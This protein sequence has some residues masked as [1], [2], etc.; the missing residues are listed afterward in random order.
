MTIYNIAL[1]L[2]IVGALIMGSAQVL[3]TIGVN[4]IRQAKTTMDLGAVFGFVR[5]LSSLYQVSGALIL[6]SGIYLTIAFWGAEAWIIISLVMVLLLAVSGP[7]VSGVRFREIGQRSAAESGTLSPSLRS[8]TQ[9]PILEWSHYLRMGA[10]LGI[11]LLMVAKPGLVG[12]L[13]VIAAALVV[14]GAYSLLRT[15]GSQDLQPAATH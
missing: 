9:A 1:F 13:L 3:E 2:H 10:F 15:R 6:L 5:P 7:R 8:L 12:S 14:S 11:V 4:R